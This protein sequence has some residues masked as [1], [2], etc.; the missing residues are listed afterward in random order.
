MKYTDAKIHY[1][2]KKFGKCYTCTHSK[3]TQ[4]V[5]IPRKECYCNIREHTVENS[6]MCDWLMMKFCKYYEEEII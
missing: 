4:S 3:I 1:Y 2:K 6:L 5:P